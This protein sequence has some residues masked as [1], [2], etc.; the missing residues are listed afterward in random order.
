VS[1]THGAMATI[2][3]LL[4]QA[5]VAYTVI[6]AHAVNA[7]VEPRLTADVDVTAQ[8]DAAGIGRLE[9]VLGDARW[10]LD[11]QHGATQPSGPD[12][13]RF[14]STDGL[15]ELQLEVIRRALV[16]EDGVRVAT[17]E[18]LIV[19]RPIYS[20]SRRWRPST[21]RTSNAGPTRGE[22]ATCS[23]GCEPAPP[24]SSSRNARSTFLP[25]TRR[26]ASSRSSC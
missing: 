17:P 11:R 9:K 8:A 24:H 22:S 19:L 4:E 3:R 20:R 10:S 5:G 7:W 16:A 15:T 6:G 23:R 14:V 1:P 2:A 25:R 18:D 26:S 13:V 12:F 21:G